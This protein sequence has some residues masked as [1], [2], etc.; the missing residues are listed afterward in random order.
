M[1]PAAGAPELFM[2]RR[3][4]KSAF[5]AAYAFPGGV[6]DPEDHMVHDACVGVP[7]STANANLG[8]K[9]DGLDYYSA[10]IR[11]LFEESGVLLANRRDVAEGLDSARDALN[12]RSDNWADFV[13]RNNLELQC[14]RLHY[15][16]HWI[17]PTPM[18]K[19]CSTRFFVAAMPDGQVA[20]HCGGELTD[21]C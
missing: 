19:R 6:V 21:S 14:D 11:E 18:K 8:V 9:K 7:V 3:H 1:R 2:V 15:V 4:A 16:S 17:T 20:S 5:G 12:D 13:A 10:A